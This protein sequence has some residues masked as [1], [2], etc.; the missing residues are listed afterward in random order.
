MDSITNELLDG[1]LVI[2]GDGKFCRSCEELMCAKVK[3][4]LPKNNSVEYSLLIDRR[5]LA[6]VDLLRKHPD[7]KPVIESYVDFAVGEAVKI[8]DME[9]AGADY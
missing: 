2:V 8:H 4:I 7:L 6:M 3:K 5:I 1:S 9:Q